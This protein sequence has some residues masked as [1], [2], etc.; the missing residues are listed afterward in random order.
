MSPG[1]NPKT[2]W[3]MGL[4]LS[5]L[6]IYTCVEI[7]ESQDVEEARKYVRT[8]YS[9]LREAELKG[10]DVE[11]AASKLD[12]ALELLRE[13]E[14]VGTLEREKSISRVMSMAG[15][16]ESSIGRL[17]EEGESRNR[18]RIITL[19]SSAALAALSSILTYLYAPRIFWGLW[20]RARR[21]WRVK[22]A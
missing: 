17:V 1:N 14:G 11:E 10:A 8:V 2:I 15:E 5:I 19:S 13:V 21:D 18:W 3:I 6:A 22:R 20:L 4:I 16:V 9:S 7:A 12:E